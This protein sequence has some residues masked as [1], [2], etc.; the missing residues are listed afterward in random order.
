MSNYKNKDTQSEKDY[1]I[2]HAL[3][4]LVD[5]VGT[6]GTGLNVVADCTCSSTVFETDKDFTDSFF[7]GT[8][9]IDD[10]VDDFMD[11]F[12]KDFVSSFVSDFTFSSTDESESELSDSSFLSS[13]IASN[14]F[15]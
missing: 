14:F 10:F 3:D 6:L 11:D 9:D 8:E 13:K 4:L 7:D 1:K 2:K 12:D 5:L 15:R